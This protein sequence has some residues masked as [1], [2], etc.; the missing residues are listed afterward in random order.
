VGTPG[1]PDRKAG[2]LAPVQVAALSAV[3]AIAAGEVHSLALLKDGSVWAWGSNSS[4]QLGDGTKMNR[5][6]PVRVSGLS[7]V[8]A[9]AAGERH[10][11]ALKNDGTVWTWGSRGLG[12]HPGDGKGSVNWSP[13]QVPDLAEV[14][15]ISGGLVH[16]LALKK[17]G[18]VWAWGGN[19]S[20]QLGDGTRLDRTAP[21]QVL[22]LVRIRAIAAGNEFSLALTGP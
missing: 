16:S 21:V 19:S 10:S 15:E 4:G 20:G 6:V 13:V 12:E 18:T 22:G 1:N 8:Q 5:N 3:T 7:G 14:A 9:I 17:D 2:K 11:L